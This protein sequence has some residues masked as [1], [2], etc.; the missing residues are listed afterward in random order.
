MV[1]VA[2]TALGVWWLM[3]FPRDGT[4]LRTLTF[5]AAGLFLLAGIAIATAPVWL[6]MIGGPA[7]YALTDRRVM[8]ITGSR[9]RLVRS[10]QLGRIG[11]H[12]VTEKPDGAGDILF[13]GM[14]GSSEGERAYQVNGLFGVPDARRVS[15]LIAAEQ[16]RAAAAGQGAEVHPA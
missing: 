12:T 15:G 6:G 3:L 14:P 9:A 13:G 4:A 10:A 11:A 2:V 1:G 16:A 8:M 7:V 5:F